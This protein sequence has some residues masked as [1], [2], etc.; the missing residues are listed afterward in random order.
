MSTG[1]YFAFMRSTN[2]YKFQ[3]EIALNGLVS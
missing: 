3:T 2:V 1:T